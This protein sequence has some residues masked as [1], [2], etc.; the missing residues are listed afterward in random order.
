MFDLGGDWSQEAGCSK[1]RHVSV[2]TRFLLVPENIIDWSDYSMIQ[3]K[4]ISVVLVLVSVAVLMLTGNALGLTLTVAAEANHGP[5]HVDYVRWCAS[6]YEELTGIEVEVI[7]PAGQRTQIPILAAAGTLPDIVSVNHHLM[8]D[9]EGIFRDL[10]TYLERDDRLS[11]DAF[12][13]VSIDSFR[14]ENGIYAIPFSLWTVNSGINLRL[15]S[16]MGLSSPNDLNPED[17]NWDMLKEYGRK[18]TQD[19]SG[20]GYPNQFGISLSTWIHRWGMIFRHAGNPIF[21]RDVDP[22]RIMLD[23]PEALETVEFLRDLRL[24]DWVGGNFFEGNVGIFYVG[25]GPNLAHFIGDNFEG[26]FLPNPYGPADANGTEFVSMGYSISTGS[27]HPDQA[28]DFL[29][30]MWGNPDRVQRFCV[31]SDRPSAL[32]ELGPWYAEELMSLPNGRIVLDSLLYRGAGWRPVLRD[33]GIFSV[34]QNYIN[35]AIAGEIPPREALV[36]A[37]EMGTVRL[38]ESR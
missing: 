35:Q 34:I 24:Y 8:M 3:V 1:R 4:K 19:T 18:V 12:F 21:D 26:D 13:P 32:L 7:S 14:H 2:L 16:E 15:I 37:Q 11:I 33:P 38:R 31:A 22:T 9:Y 28:W 20:D 6:Q 10:T 23:T 5:E 30:F 25:A 27:R 29:S 17:W 36:H